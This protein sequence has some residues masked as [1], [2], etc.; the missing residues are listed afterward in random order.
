MPIL[1]IKNVEGTEG[2]HDLTKIIPQVHREPGL[3]LRQLALNSELVTSVQHRCS[4][5]S[6]QCLEEEGCGV[7]RQSKPRLLQIYCC[8]SF[9][10]YFH[11]LLFYDAMKRSRSWRKTYS[12][13]VCSKKQPK[14][15]KD[16]VGNVVLHPGR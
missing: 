7:G 3:A 8:N 5:V 2:L 9:V 13:D 12:K 14:L 4:L 11:F 15:R 10:H 16:G 1:H 6:L